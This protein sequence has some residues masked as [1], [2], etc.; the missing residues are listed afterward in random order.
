MNDSCL[1]LDRRYSALAHRSTT[2]ID[3]RE[4][5][6][7]LQNCSRQRNRPLQALKQLKTGI[8]SQKTGLTEPT[9]DCF[10]DAE[11][12][13]DSTVKFEYAVYPDEVCEC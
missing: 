9:L 8:L 10:N 3:S 7:F 1:K 6:T 2:H 12:L 5:Y 4:L 13:P 11:I